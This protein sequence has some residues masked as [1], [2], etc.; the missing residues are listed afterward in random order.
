MK[1]IISNIFQDEYIWREI[2]YE[3]NNIYMAESQILK[4]ENE[5]EYKCRWAVWSTVEK[6]RIKSKIKI[7]I[8]VQDEQKRIKDNNILSMPGQHMTEIK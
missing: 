3:D 2:L 7:I 5:S 8:N 6:E 1:I 4:I